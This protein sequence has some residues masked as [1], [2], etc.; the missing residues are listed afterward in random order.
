MYISN[1]VDDFDDGETQSIIDFDSS[2]AAKKISRECLAWNYLQFENMILI[3]NRDLES[4]LLTADSRSYFYNIQLDW[5]KIPI[6]L[7]SKQK[8]LS[9]FTSLISSFIPLPNR[10][11]NYFYLHFSCQLLSI[12]SDGTKKYLA[13]YSSGN[14]SWMYIYHCDDTYIISEHFGKEDKCWETDFVSL[15]SKI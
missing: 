7:T 10:I 4:V 6:Q 5:C 14:A 2:E 12:E 9:K 8:I 13:P 11:S 1:I 15:N 3:D